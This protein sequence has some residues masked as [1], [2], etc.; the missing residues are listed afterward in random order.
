MAITPPGNKRNN[1]PDIERTAAEL[2]EEYCARVGGE[3][4]ANAE[5]A[6]SA[7]GL[8]KLRLFGKRVG[9]RE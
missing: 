8:H 5:S 4:W 7:R 6:G 2:Y 1:M 9:L 3:A